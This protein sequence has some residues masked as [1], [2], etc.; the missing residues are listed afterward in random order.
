MER[1]GGAFRCPNCRRTCFRH[2]NRRNNMLGRLMQQ[3][4]VR[5]PN[6]EITANRALYIRQQREAEQ[7]QESK[8]DNNH[9]QRGRNRNRNRD[10]DREREQDRRNDED[11]DRSR[12]RSRERF[13]Y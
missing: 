10:R 4:Q 7:K 13:V 3:L 11:R 2:R 12:S 6:H 1:S 9:D 8:E 5:C